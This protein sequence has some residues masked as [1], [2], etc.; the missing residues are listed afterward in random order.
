MSE[1]FA[2]VAC[3]FVF[4]SATTNTAKW[5]RLASLASNI[6]FVLYAFYHDLTPIL[7]LHGILAPMNTMQLLRALSDERAKKSAAAAGDAATRPYVVAR[8]A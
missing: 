2:Y 6:C 3:G 7:F 4:F 5:F 8:N 1:I